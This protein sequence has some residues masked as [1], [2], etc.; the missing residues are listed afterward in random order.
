MDDAVTRCQDAVT[1]ELLLA[2][3]AALFPTGYSGMAKIRVGGYREHAEPM[4]IVSGRLDRQQV[5]YKA[6]PSARVPDEMG[7]LLDWFNAG[8]ACDEASK[9][10]DDTLVKARFWLD[11]G[12]KALNERQRKVMNALLD[13]G[14]GGFE[15]G[16]STRKYE[17]ITGAS[18]ATASRELIDLEAMGLLQ[19]VGAGRSTRYYV[20]LTGWVPSVRDR[21]R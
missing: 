7:H 13:A 5:H 17:N 11:H 6:P 10:V 2:W 16:M 3:H 18:R 20:R 4:Q 1:H 15:G 12:S 8:A 19:Q 9:V 21:S 14:R